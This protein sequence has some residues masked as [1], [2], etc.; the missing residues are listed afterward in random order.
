[1]TL[2]RIYV[3]HLLVDIAIFNDSIV[4]ADVLEFLIKNGGFDS[5]ITVIKSK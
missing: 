1:M 5:E 2:W 4:E 3:D